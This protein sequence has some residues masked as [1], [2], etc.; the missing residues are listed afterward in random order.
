MMTNRESDS[1]FVLRAILST[2]SQQ[3]TRGSIGR[4][5]CRFYVL[6]RLTQVVPYTFIDCS[7]SWLQLV[8]G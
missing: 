3:F 4:E 5:I 1:I 2:C 7:G 8:P 6:G